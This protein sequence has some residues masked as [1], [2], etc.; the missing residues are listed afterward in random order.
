MQ[1]FPMLPHFTVQEQQ[2][3]L[4]NIASSLSEGELG[5]CQ[6][7]RGRCKFSKILN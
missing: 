7:H 6:D 1:I 5:S 4:V 2:I 3:T